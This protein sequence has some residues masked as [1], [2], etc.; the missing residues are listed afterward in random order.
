MGGNG[1]ST[2]VP[3]VKKLVFNKVV[4][5]PLGM[6]KQVFL[7]HFEPM[8]LRFGPWKILRRWGWQPELPGRKSGETLPSLE[9]G[10]KM[11]ELAQLN[12]FTPEVKKGGASH[13]RFIA[14]CWQALGLG[15]D[16]VCGEDL[17]LDADLVGALGDAGVQPAG[18]QTAGVCRIGAW[19][20]LPAQVQAQARRNPRNWGPPA[21]APPPTPGTPSPRPWGPSAPPWTGK[22]RYVDCVLALISRTVLALI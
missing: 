13:W 22:A 20:R 8:V 7:A 5:R 11:I 1:G 9:K 10:V 16:G 19:H 2:G 6:L 14:M 18:G 15:G 12:L 4:P 21:A 3:G 17:N